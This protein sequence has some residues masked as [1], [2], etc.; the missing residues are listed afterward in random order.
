MSA[1]R[2]HVTMG[3]ERYWRLADLS[4]AQLDTLPLG[5]VVIDPSGVVSAYNSYES[6]LS[7][8]RPE[9]VIGR[10]FFRDIAPC[11]AV[12]AFE[13]RM[14]SFMRSAEDVSETFDYFFPFAHGQV[15]VTI[16]FVKMPDKRSILIAIER[17]ERTPV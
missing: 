9:D 5:A 13:G 12:Q 11:T 10:N 17:S 4:Q 7:H 16:T 2:E 3:K 14:R 8:L 6:S 15:D 1:A